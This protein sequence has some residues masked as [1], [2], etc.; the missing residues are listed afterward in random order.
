MHS[1]AYE[2]SAAAVEQ[3]ARARSEKRFVLAAGT[4]VVRALEDA[5]QKGESDGFVLRAGKA[6]ADL[7]I[8]PG[9]PFRIVDQL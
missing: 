5:A 4:T 7:F 2:I 3:I 8:R 6:E 9:H 1:E